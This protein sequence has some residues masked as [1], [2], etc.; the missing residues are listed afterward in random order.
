MLTNKVSLITGA[1]SGIGL[2]CAEKLASSGSHLII[3]GRRV[4]RLEEISARL[5]SEYGVQVVS[6]KLDV[7]HKE[8][9]IDSLAQ[10]PTSLA[11]IDILINN[12]GLAAGVDLVSEANTDDWDLMIDTNLK[13][14][15]YVTRAILPG[16]IKRN[17]GHILNIASTAGHIV[18]PGGSVY[19]ATKH[20]VRAVAKT[21]QLELM[22]YNIRVSSVDPGM[23]KTEFSDVRFKGDKSKS[24]D[25]YKGF[26]PLFPED[27]ADAV[28]YCVTRPP[29]VMIGEMVLLAT[30]QGDG[31]TVSRKK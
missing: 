25:V 2:A 8:E 28:S 9:V 13:G 10:I 21:L 1:T 26:T 27:V 3:T 17:A 22:D 19:C 7:R 16:M 5:S 31:K 24:E 20:A 11:S 30:A 18:Y 4:E 23:V 14:L 12:A 15:L 29:H 6:L